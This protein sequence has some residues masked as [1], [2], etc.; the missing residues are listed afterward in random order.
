MANKVFGFLKE[1]GSVALK[2]VTAVPRAAVT[3]AK[4]LEDGS[5]L[6]PQAKQDI[7]LLIDDAESV[8]ANVTA[9]T[10][11]GLTNWVADATSVAAVEKLVSDSLRFYLRLRATRKL[12]LRTSKTL[13]P[14]HR[15][16]EC[17]A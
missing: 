1:A 3:V 6:E 2:V 15:L 13:M 12:S 4:L 9:A 10:A 7:L 16:P 11:G 5:K 17:L 8:A 14:L